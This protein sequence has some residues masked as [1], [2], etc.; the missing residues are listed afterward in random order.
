LSADQHTS[1]TIRFKSL[2]WFFTASTSL[3]LTGF[4][5]GGIFDICH[6]LIL[7]WCNFIGVFLVYRFN[8]CIDQ[9][10][11]LKFNLKFFFSFRVHRIVVGQFVLITIPIAIYFLN[12]FTLSVLAIGAIAGVL[13]SVNFRIGNF[14]FRLKNIFLVKNLLIGAIWGSLILA[15]AGRFDY[16][17]LVE[18]LF[19]YTSLQ[20]FIGG[21]IRDVPDLEKDRLAGVKSFPVVF[22]IRNTIIFM[23][24][25]NFASYAITAYIYKEPALALLPLPTAWRFVNLLLLSTAP[26]DKRWHQIMNLSTC[27]LILISPIVLIFYLILAYA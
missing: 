2:V 24:I 1:N 9:D 12:I 27:T 4:L 6:L 16:R 5:V 19:L 11:D 25:V 22:G 13:Y 8:D 3:L 7:M 26:N 17:E 21:M 14:Q 23:H 15:G 10:Q 18:L 20:V